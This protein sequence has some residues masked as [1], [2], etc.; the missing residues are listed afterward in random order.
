MLSLCTEYITWYAIAENDTV[1]YGCLYHQ[2]TKLGPR[3]LY[4]AHP[5]LNLEYSTLLY[6]RYSHTSIVLTKAL[7][8]TT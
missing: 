2:F 8:T 5:A 1:A 4:L 3:G 7:T 6:Y